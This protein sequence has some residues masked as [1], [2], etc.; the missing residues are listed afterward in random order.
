MSFKDIL[1][2]I[3]S[4]PQCSA[5]LALAIGLA[6]RHKAY[7]TGLYVISHPHY[8][9]RQESS[10]LK[11]EE[12]RKRFTE[13]T[14]HAGIPAIWRDIDWNVS[15]V[16][17][18]E[19][20]NL[21]AYHKDLVIIGQTDY[22]TQSGDIPS[23]MPERVVVGS[24]RP[25]LIVPYAGEF[26]SLGERVMI[27][28]RAGRESGRALHDAF[29]ILEKAKQVNV[30]AVNLAGTEGNTGNSCCD[31]ITTHLA[32]H[33]IDAKTDKFTVADMQVGDVLLNSAWEEGCDLLV[34]GAYSITTRGSANLGPVAR[35]ILKHMTMPIL[36]SH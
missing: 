17:T 11:I 29:P 6:Q 33:G 25:V 24:G 15:G 13:T 5:R 21:H 9:S 30:I 19:I 1:V 3:D 7:L 12:A 28:W 10:G 8:K 23:D 16:S 35:H 18:A 27:A 14:A 32:R 26:K 34:M 36:M 2:H 31:E 4:S 22:G 20:L